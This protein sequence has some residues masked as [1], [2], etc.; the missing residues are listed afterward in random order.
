MWRISLSVVALAL[1]VVACS[2]SSSSGGSTSSGSGPC[3]PLAA[4]ATSLTGVLGVGQDGSGTLYVADSPAGSTEPR[5]FVSVGG[6]LVRQH[7]AGSGATGS[8]KGETAAEYTL[9]FEPAGADFSAARAL[10][11]AMQGGTASQMALGPADSKSFIGG[12][13]ETPLK[14]VGDGTVAGMPIV[15][16]PNIVDDVADVSDGTAIVIT[17]PFD[18]NSSADFHLFYG[19]PSAMQERTIV[20]FDQDA[21]GDGGAIIKFTVGSATYTMSIAGEPDPDAG[22]APTAGT[23]DTGTQQLTFTLRMPTPTTLSGFSFACL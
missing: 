8:G 3:D 14:V 22:A 9:T 19:K 10:L 21:S 2:S 15:N 4:P 20:A 7:V 11:L 6:K 18:L 1:G 5:V 23:L 12:P 13:G 17:S 16:L